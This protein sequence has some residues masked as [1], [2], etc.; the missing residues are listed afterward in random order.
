MEPWDYITVVFP[1]NTGQERLNISNELKV[2]WDA[3]W[4]TDTNCERMDDINS[5][6]RKSNIVMEIRFRRVK[7]R[8]TK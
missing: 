6:P 1:Y 4:F 5:K 8:K 2:Y 3:G 7:L